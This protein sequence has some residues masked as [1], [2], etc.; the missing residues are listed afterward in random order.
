[1]TMGSGLPPDEIRAAACAFE[2]TAAV[3]HV[4]TFCPADS[5]FDRWTIELTPAADASGLPPAAARI[6]AKHRL[7]VRDVSPQ[8]SMYRAV[9]IV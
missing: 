2:A 6:G 1:M 9:L 5:S 7:T 4:L 8:G 3:R